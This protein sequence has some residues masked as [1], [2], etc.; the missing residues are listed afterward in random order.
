MKQKLKAHL[1]TSGRFFATP[2]F[3]SSLVLGAILAGSSFTNPNLW[4]GLIAGL[5]VMAGGH[6]FNSYLDYAW[7]G[8]DKGETE[9]RSAEKG[10]TGGQSLIATGILS[11]KEVLINA[12]SWY[13][14]ALIP[15]IYLAINVGWPIVLVAVLGMLITFWYA[16]GKFN[17]THELSL[18]VGVGPL[19]VLMGMFAV[20][21]NADWV[22][23]LVVSF[24]FAILLCFAGLALDEW[25]DAEANLKKGV[26]S[27]AYKVWEYGVDLGT[28]IMLW[29]LLMYAYQVFLISIGI[30]APLTGL[31]FICFPA[32]MALIVMMKG[33]FE[34]FAGK[35]V[36][37]AA[38][39]PIL[40]VVGQALGG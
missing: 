35:I 12:L 38:F 32:F 26:K 22:V 28:Y 17:W 21:P 4:L 36:L 13:A 7:T 3:G 31:T 10:Y 16:K 19:A 23:G 8:L 18:G 2:F 9:E 24:P 1:W 39:Y 15:I 11:L 33:D 29:L 34:K 30:L 37:V 20:T 40:L 14:L 5:L 27:I 6:S 25:P